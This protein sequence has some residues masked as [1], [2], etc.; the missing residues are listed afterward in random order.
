MIAGS[1]ATLV[2]DLV[3]LMNKLQKLFWYGDLFCFIV[4]YVKL[5]IQL[6]HVYAQ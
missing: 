5:A 6:C 3:K 2:M 4:Q 1:I